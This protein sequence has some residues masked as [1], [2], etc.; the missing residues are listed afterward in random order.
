MNTRLLMG[1]ALL[2][3]AIQG[4]AAPASHSG[5]GAN[6]AAVISVNIESLDF[7]TVEIGYPVS[8][9][10]L[11]TG[12]NLKDNINLSF[13]KYIYVFKAV[14]ETITPEEAAVGKTVK[15]TYYPMG[16]WPN[17]TNLILSSTDAQDVSIPVCA[18]T[19]ISN[20]LFINKQTVELS[21]MVG[22]FATITGTVWFPDAEIPPDPNVPMVR[23]Q[24]FDMLTAFPG[25]IIPDYY[26][27]WIDGENTGEFRA[28]FTRASTIANICNVTITYAPKSV[29]SHQAKLHLSCSKAGVPYLYINLRGEAPSVLGDLDGNGILGITDVTDMID[30][31]LRGNLNDPASDMDDDG[32]LT[33]TD[34]VTLISRILE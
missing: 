31:L 8:K 32:K 22:R 13:D 2:I 30:L 23:D 28:M 4:W 3:L 12:T 10:I 7:G 5:R 16:H 9:T 20:Q 11:V 24:S 33:I 1:V 19:H 6:E 21:T 15:I 25:G 27:L 29:G 26:S 34:V 14:P 18:D 17:Q